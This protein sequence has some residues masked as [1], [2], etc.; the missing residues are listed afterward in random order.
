MQAE[1]SFGSAAI[2]AGGRSLRMGFDKQLI[3]VNETRLFEHIYKNLGGHF[4]DLMVVTYHPE[5]YLDYPVRTVRDIY[6]GSGP[7]AGIHSALLSARSRYVYVVA[8]DMPNFNPAY[9]AYMEKQ[10][11]RH[12]PCACVTEKGGWIEPFHA[13]YSVNCL[14][15]IED[16]LANSKTSIRYFLDKTDM[17]RIPEAKAREFSPDWSMF[18][19]INTKELYDQYISGSQA[20]S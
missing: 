10:L 7:L 5:F 12:E 2:L 17:L 11:R 15:L 13:Y 8:C 18:L 4:S 14:P 9:A 20:I 16:E 19:N 6:E 1:S 3:T